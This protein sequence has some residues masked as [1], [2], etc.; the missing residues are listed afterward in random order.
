ME[1]RRDKSALEN[2]VQRT[3]TKLGQEDLKFKAAI[4]QRDQAVQHL[5][6]LCQIFSKVQGQ[7]LEDYELQILKQAKAFGVEFKYS[8]DNPKKI[9]ERVEET[10]NQYND[11]KFS[12]EMEKFDLQRQKQGFQAKM[13][14]ADR[15][16]K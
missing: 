3:E 10:I 12:L 2:K 16:F 13:K 6:K 15:K 1:L 4:E 11:L 5:R 14:E 9:A 8:E 7:G